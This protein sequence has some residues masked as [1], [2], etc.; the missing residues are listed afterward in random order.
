M[1]ALS[2]LFGIKQQTARTQN[3]CG[4]WLASRHGAVA[5]SESQHQAGSKQQA[6]TKGQ[7][8]SHRYRL[9]IHFAVHQGGCEIGCRV[10]TMAVCAL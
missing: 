7:T 2:P 3:A 4:Q 1:A 5:A 8:S 6:A 9:L 10:P